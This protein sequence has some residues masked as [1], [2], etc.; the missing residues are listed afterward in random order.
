MHG[1]RNA[2][3]MLLV[4]LAAPGVPDLYQGSELRADAL[5]DPDNR[6]PVDLALRE[7][8]LRAVSDLGARE[9]AGGDLSRAK[10][11]TIRRVLALR[12]RAP[13]LFDGAYR[14]LRAHG[15]HAH[16]VFAFARG[17][18]LVAVVPRLG[19]DA[20]GW[21]ATTL[22]LPPGTWRDALSDHSHSGGAHDVT[23]LWTALPIALLV[24]DD[25]RERLR[26][27]PNASK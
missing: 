12:R 4:K 22:E 17:E 21:R 10:L 13:A 20:D 8:E 6:A 11:F 19:A 5:V 18:G 24:S 26:P 1:D 9:I 3:A 27:A 16:R 14:P 15:P 23:V 25:A 7:R 2:L